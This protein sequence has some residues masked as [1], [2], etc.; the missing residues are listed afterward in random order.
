MPLGLFSTKLAIDQT[1]KNF[2]L[3]LKVLNAVNLNA[4]KDIILSSIRPVM[5]L[6][7]A[8]KYVMYMNSDYNSN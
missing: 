2:L 4:F 1:V 6:N 5:Q 3:V 7:S 8:T